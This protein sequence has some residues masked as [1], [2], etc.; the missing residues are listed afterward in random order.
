MRLFSKIILTLTAGLL[1]S[2]CCD[3]Y[4]DLSKCK[5]PRLQFV[6]NA[7]G[8]ENVLKQYISSGQL[9]VYDE[10][11]NLYLEQPL[12][13]V[14]FKHGVML[15]GIHSGKWHVVAWGNADSHTEI[16]AREPL[17]EATLSTLADNEGVY[18]TTDSLYR[19]ELLLDVDALPQGE[20]AVVP[21]SSAHVSFDVFIEGF[22]AFHG[23]EGAQPL[24]EI[25]KAGTLYKFSGHPAA[26][27]QPSA[28]APFVPSMVHSG[29]Q[30][31]YRA[32]FDLFRIEEIQD[33]TLTLSTQGGTSPE[34]LHTIPLL[35]YVREHNIPLTATNEVN[36]PIKITFEGNL[37]VNIEPFAW[38]SISI[39]PDGY[40]T[41][42]PF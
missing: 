1:L 6:Y 34:V 32:R 5:T 38:G 27:P 23:A 22:D 24:L 19:A 33:I 16:T 14:D 37:V 15:D 30:D 35:D 39:K 2:S 20:D 9:F 21:Y 41:S 7:D 29:S 12:T 40:K 3:F 42:F 4:D 17:A 13:S 25:N 18:R 10:S 31:L 26:I 8:S 11:G 36:I 28:W